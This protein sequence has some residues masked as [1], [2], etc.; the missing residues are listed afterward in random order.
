MPKVSEEHKR[1]RREEIARAA[2]RC[3]GEKGYAATSMADII[4]ESGLSAGAIYGYYTNKSELVREAMRSVVVGRFTEL[5]R[6]R[7]GKATLR[8]SELVV[9]FLQGVTEAVVRPG[10]IVQ[11]WANAQLDPALEETVQGAVG[12]IGRLFRDYLEAWYVAGGM[13]TSEAQTRAQAEYPVY[14]A[15]CQG[16]L[17]HAATVRDFDRAAYFDAVTRVLP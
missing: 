3:F 10:L 6:A 11:V 7:E 4:R 5:E 15:V 8:P 9:E 14:V 12:E 1:A 2:L 13:A 17:V 16:Y